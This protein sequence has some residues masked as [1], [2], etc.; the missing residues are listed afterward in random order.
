MVPHL[1]GV[2][3]FPQLTPGMIVVAQLHLC[4]GVNRDN[5]IPA[6]LEFRSFLCNPVE[7]GISFRMCFTNLIVFLVL[8]KRIA[9]LFDDPLYCCMAIATARPRKYFIAYFLS[10]GIDPFVTRHRISVG[11]FIYDGI[12]NPDDI[13][14][15]VKVSAGKALLRHFHAVFLLDGPSTAARLPAAVA[16]LVDLAL[17]DF[18]H[19]AAD[20]LSADM[21]VAAECGN[22]ATPFFQCYA[23]KIKT[24]S[25][26][27]Q[28]LQSNC[29]VFQFLH[30]EQLFS[31]GS[32][33]LPG[34]ND[35]VDNCR[36]L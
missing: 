7:L 20:P 21:T 33:V 9:K 36:F 27:R 6:A 31:H 32:L 2:M 3:L 13:S 12:N 11:T 22:G 25:L 17:K 5:R 24:F 26:F 30:C 23:P 1:S 16:N 4:L 18:T 34:G 14:C 28:P 19:S 35:A 15:C 8:L 29:Y 10:G